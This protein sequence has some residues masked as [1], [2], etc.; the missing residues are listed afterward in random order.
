[1]KAPNP[2]CGNCEFWMKSR[3]CPR[4]GNGQKGPSMNVMPCNKYLLEWAEARKLTAPE[5]PPV[6]TAASPMVVWGELKPM[7]L[8]SGQQGYTLEGFCPNENKIDVYS[9]WTGYG[10]DGVT[11][12][13][14]KFFDRH[15]HF[16]SFDKAKELIEDSVR[17]Y[18]QGKFEGAKANLAN[19]MYCLGLDHPLS[20]HQRP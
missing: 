16:S 8:A 1:M 20:I 5:L 2:R 18:Y 19:L 14:C 10:F 6:R 17:V 4:E 12:S 7:P 13:P 3:Q 9:Y 15:Q 11:A